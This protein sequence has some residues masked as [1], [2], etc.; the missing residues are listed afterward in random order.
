MLLLIGLLIYVK[1]Q[2]KVY[3]YINSLHINVI[4]KNNVTKVI[5]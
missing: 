3:M 2:I 5:D 1:K 4:H